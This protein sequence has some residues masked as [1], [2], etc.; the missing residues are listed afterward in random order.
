MDS[1]CFEIA[2]VIKQFVCGLIHS[3]DFLQS[4]TFYARVTI[5][6]CFVSVTGRK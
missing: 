6:P 3:H 5:F 2:A 1:K 4:P